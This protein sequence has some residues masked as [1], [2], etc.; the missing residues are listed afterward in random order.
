MELSMRKRLLRARLNGTEHQDKF[1]L[2]NAI[3]SVS[4]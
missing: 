3:L 2:G 4:H 1:V